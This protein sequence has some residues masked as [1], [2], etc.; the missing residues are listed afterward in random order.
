MKKRKFK[1][2][3]K[4]REEFEKHLDKK[5]REWFLEEMGKGFPSVFGVSG[6]SNLFSFGRKKIE[7]GS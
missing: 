1:L 6:F 7:E 4:D 2:S 5:R 3:S